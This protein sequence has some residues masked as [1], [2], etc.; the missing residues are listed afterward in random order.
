MKWYSLERDLDD[1]I[2]GEDDSWEPSEKPT[3]T[4]KLA[5]VFYTQKSRVIVDCPG[6]LLP[7]AGAGHEKPSLCKG[8]W[9]GASRD[10]GIAMP[11]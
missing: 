8:R 11:V 2:F 7:C 9:H 3:T 6:F 5:W 10:G 4:R 1:L